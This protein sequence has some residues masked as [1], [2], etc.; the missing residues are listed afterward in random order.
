MARWSMD[1][2]SVIVL[3]QP[4]ALWLRSDLLVA[5]VMHNRTISCWVIVDVAIPVSRPSVLGI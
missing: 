3:P 1:Y 5:V 4:L 2:L